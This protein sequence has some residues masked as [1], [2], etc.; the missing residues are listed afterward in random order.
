MPEP[1]VD[2]VIEFLL[3]SFGGRAKREYAK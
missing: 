3:S 1:F 2:S